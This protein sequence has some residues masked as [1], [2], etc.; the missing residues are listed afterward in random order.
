MVFV[1]S[2][3]V[4]L[5]VN[6]QFAQA[7]R[8]QH[9]NWR[10]HC[11]IDELRPGSLGCRHHLLLCLCLC[12]SERNQLQMLQADYGRPMVDPGRK[13]QSVSF[14]VPSAFSVVLLRVSLL[15]LCFST[16]PR[17]KLWTGWETQD[18]KL[19]LWTSLWQMGSHVFSL[20]SNL[21]TWWG[22][23]SREDIIPLVCMQWIGVYVYIY[24][25][26]YMYVCMY[27]CMYVWISQKSLWYFL[28]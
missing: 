27:V 1:I 7:P 2:S 4:S 28:P 5:D 10:D 25:Y 9:G 8:G 19:S 16:T 26:E 6:H 14:F 18:H 3:H 23:R 17:C 12:D 13:F 22:R 20:A 11:G 24:I 15:H 21:S